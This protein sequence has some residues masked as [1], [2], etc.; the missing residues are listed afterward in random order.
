[1]LAL[2]VFG[3]LA[4]LVGLTTWV[5]SLTRTDVGVDAVTPGRL[6][7][8]PETRGIITLGSG[9]TVSLYLDGFH[10]AKDDHVL[11]DTVRVG[12]PVV[13]VLGTLAPGSGGA[14]HRERITATLSRIHIKTLSIT[15]GSATWT[16]EA[17]G[18]VEGRTRVVPLRWR[19]HLD[20]DQIRTTV[21]MDGV[22]ALVLPLA[23]R[24]SVVG[25]PPALPKRNLRLRKWWFADDSGLDPA[26]TWVRGAGL[27]I[28]PVGV[29]RA[30]DVS[31]DGRI[32]VHV[33]SASVEFVVTELPGA[34]PAP[35]TSPTAT[36]V[37]AS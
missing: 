21:E 18:D 26:F 14:A 4:L 24:P 32:D 15:A 25:I 34:T 12:S 29:P 20:G 28:G 35:S 9:W 16:G 3:T 1:M 7:A 6:V 27:G 8:E 22:D 31:H 17:S 36:P 2:V 13:G 10:Y 37:P 30:I 19:V 33:W 11:A 23:W 5:P